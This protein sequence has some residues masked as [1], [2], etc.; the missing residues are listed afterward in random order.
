MLL[1][2]KTDQIDLRTGA[3]QCARAN[4]GHADPLG[5][6]STNN[7]KRFSTHCR[8]LLSEITI[9]PAQK[10]GLSAA[11]TGINSGKRADAPYP[12]IANGELWTPDVA[13]C[14]G[15]GCD[16]FMLARGAARISAPRSLR[17]PRQVDKLA[18]LRYNSYW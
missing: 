15:S 6:D 3:R 13:R 4:A 1:R 11:R 5:Y 17:P 14:A 8:A 9:M 7:L 2:S 12:V 16:A 10:T 18:G